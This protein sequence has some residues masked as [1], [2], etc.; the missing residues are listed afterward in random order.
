MS[1]LQEFL[2]SNPID[3]LTEE[4][5]ISER[6]KDRD[7]NV[8]KFKIRAMTSKEFDDIRKRSMRLKK[9][10]QFELDVERFNSAIVINQ[11]VVPDFRNAASI[12]KL[13]CAT[14]EEYLNK[15]LLA[16]EIA[17]LVNQIQRLS[18]FDRDMNE[19]IDEAKTD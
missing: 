9:G 5:V 3:N 12:E 14:P 11:T 2:N 16:G 18:G 4:V 1:T 13:G 17:E 15:V 19:L 6:F 8:L 10:R 7:G